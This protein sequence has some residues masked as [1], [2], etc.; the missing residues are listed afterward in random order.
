MAGPNGSIVHRVAQGCHILPICYRS[1]STDIE[2]SRHKSSECCEPGLIET[3][4]A[5]SVEPA[6]QLGKRNIRFWVPPLICSL[7][8][9]AERC[10]SATVKVT[11]RL[12]LQVVGQLAGKFSEQQVRQAVAFL[13]DEG[14]IYSTIDDLHFKS[15]A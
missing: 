10:L 3:F 12:L 13:S 2:A 11:D 1:S 9:A 8:M 7:L 5:L 14:Q 4:V 6:D 15:C